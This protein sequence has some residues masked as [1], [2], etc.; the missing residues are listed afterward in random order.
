[1][2]VHQPFLLRIKLTLIYFVMQVLGA[3]IMLLVM[4]FNAGIFLTVVVGLTF[5]NMITPKPETTEH[6]MMQDLIQ[7]TKIYKPEF[8]KCCTEHE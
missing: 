7:V 1:M 5:G 6:H 3:F 4:T 2:T 8:E